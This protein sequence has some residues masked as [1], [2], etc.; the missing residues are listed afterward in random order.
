LFDQHSK[1]DSDKVHFIHLQSE[2]PPKKTAPKS[3]SSSARKTPVRKAKNPKPLAPVSAAPK[4]TPKKS[5]VSVASK[6]KSKSKSSLKTG[7]KKS[8]A[9]K[10]LTHPPY[11][12]MIATAI[13]TLK[14]RKGS[15]PQAIANFIITNYHVDPGHH[16]RLSLKSGTENEVFVKNNASYRLGPN[17][18]TIVKL[19][20]NKSAAK[21]SKVGK[22]A[23]AKSKPKA[24]ASTPPNQKLK[25]VLNHSPVKAKTSAVTKPKKKIVKSTPKAKASTARG[26][27]SAK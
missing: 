10:N 5:A 17:A 9:K 12:V 22:S 6:S 19:G 25:Q 11:K 8:I 13:Q 4:V 24:K 18:K 16:L 20:M 7:P 14:S 27:R 1:Y 3:P 21:K 15:S 2:M 26:G 23:S